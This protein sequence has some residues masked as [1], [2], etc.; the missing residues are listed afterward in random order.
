MCSGGCAMEWRWAPRPP[1]RKHASRPHSCASPN[2][3]GGRRS[4]PR[5]DG[6]GEARTPLSRHLMTGQATDSPS[7]LL[8]LNLRLPGTDTPSKPNSRC[9]LR[10]RRL[11]RTHAPA[12]PEPALYLLCSHCFPGQVPRPHCQRGPAAWKLGFHMNLAMLST[13]HCWPA[14]AY[15]PLCSAL[16]P[17]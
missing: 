4:P 17:P 3:A 10:R 1:T 7:T 8:S 5:A 15:P 9:G 11:H 13:N 2:G 12:T 14:S 16:G 6:P